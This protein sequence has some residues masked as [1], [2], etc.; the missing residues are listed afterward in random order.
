MGIHTRADFCED[1]FMAKEST[2]G[3]MEGIMRCHSYIYTF[4]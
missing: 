3:Q 2:P 4:L 1:S